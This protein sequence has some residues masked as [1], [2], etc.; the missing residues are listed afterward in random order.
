MIICVQSKH[1]LVT[2]IVGRGVVIWFT[3]ISLYCYIYC[4]ELLLWLQAEMQPI[5]TMALCYYYRYIVDISIFRNV[6]FGSTEC[7]K[8]WNTDTISNIETKPVSIWWDVLYAAVG[9]ISVPSLVWG[10]GITLNNR[11]VI[12]H[13]RYYGTSHTISWSGHVIRLPNPS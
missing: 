10:S 1:V 8:N 4:G 5:S 7:A 2:F 12:T 9:V 13:Q 6:V 3:A 11:K